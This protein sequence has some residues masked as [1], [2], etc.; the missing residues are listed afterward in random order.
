MPNFETLYRLHYGF[1]L[2]YLLKLTKNQDLADELTQETFFKAY[3]N[4]NSLKQADKVAVWLCQIAKNTYFSWCK[5]QKRF[6]SSEVIDVSSLS[7]NENIE[8]DYIEKEKLAKAM[9]QI[10]ILSE[11]YREVFLLRAVG[12]ISMKAISETFGKSESWARVTYYRA[13]QKLLEGMG[14]YNEM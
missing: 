3:M 12:G 4:L 9:E 5:K 6:L 1:I 11:P 7:T 10:Q 14:E 8:S 2:K 13:K